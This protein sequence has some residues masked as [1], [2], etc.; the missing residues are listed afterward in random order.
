M[1]RTISLLFVFLF[2]AVCKINAQ[3]VNVNIAVTGYHG[4]VDVF[5]P[6][7]NYNPKNFISI[8]KLDKSGKGNYTTVLPKPGYITLYFNLPGF[9]SFQYT[10]F[11]SPGDDLQFKVQF[12]NNAPKQVS[13]SGKGSNNNQPEIFALTNLDFT[14]FKGD[15]MPYRAIAAIK[16]QE[17]LNKSILKKY[18][19]QYK[20]SEAFIKN[21]Q[22]NNEYFTLIT[23]YE[24]YHNKFPFPNNPQYDK[25]QRIEDSLIS[26]RKINNDAALMAY[27][28]DHFLENFLMRE[29][30]IL[31]D[32]EHLQP[33]AF[34]RD[35]YHTSVTKGR[36]MYAGL[37]SNLFYE[38]IINKYFTGKTAERVY[39]RMLRFHLHFS[40]Y[41][42]LEL[43]FQHF[44]QRYP[45]SS[46]IPVF[47]AAI[48]EI[49]AKE[50]QTLNANMVFVADDGTKLNT[51][52]DVVRLMKGKTVFVDMWGTWCGPCRLELEKFT[53]QIRAHF[54]GKGVTFLYIDNKDSD[55]R[56]QWKKVI[57]YYK[58][59]GTHILANQ[60]LDNDIM[61]QLKA[62]GYPTH[63]IIKKDGSI[64]KTKIQDEVNTQELIKEIER[65]M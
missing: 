2:F 61:T 36:K 65:E 18:I 62:T 17:V 46:Y 35:W 30:P 5:D 26:R 37:S 42:D 4:D 16:S 53:P 6:T 63:F 33:V 22:V 24:F 11:V 64:I 48:A 8:I 38:S 21:M 19:E 31:R 15:V 52:Q 45:S 51:L 58:I 25:W 57:E 13:V 55:H 28:Y 27:N 59:E 14:K 10:L 3:K 12:V 39:A 34:Y 44:K 29:G 7:V 60:H 1:K 32:K 47:S 49:V 23:Y 54:K 43:V 50:K 20:P 41:K 9:M 40:E 56:E